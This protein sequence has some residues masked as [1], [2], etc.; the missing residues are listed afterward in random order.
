MSEIRFID[1]TTRDGVQSLWA[2]RLTTPQFLAIA[3]VMDSAGFKAIECPMGG[4]GG[5]NFAPRFL[6]EHPWERF[7]LIC[8]AIKRTPLRMWMRSRGLHDFSS[9]P[10]PHALA[11][12]W[13][14]RWAHYGVRHVI[15]LEEENDFGNIPELVRHAKSLGM[16]VSTPI[17]YSLSPV[18]TPEYYVR[19]AKEAI[20]AGTD[21]IEIKDQGGLLTPETTRSFVQAI[22]EG[23]EGKVDL[24]F[25]THCT[26]GLGLLSTLEAIRHGITSIR[27][28]LPPLAEG[29][30][31]PSTVAIMRNAAYM[32]HTT[33]LDP[34]ALQSISEHFTYVAKKEGLP[35][36]APR[37][38][39]VF[40]YDHQVPGG[41]QGTLRW[42]LAQLKSEHRFDEVLAETAQVRKDMGYPIMVTPASQFIVAQ[43]TMNVLSGERYKTVC[44]EVIE[45]LVL[46]SAIQPPGTPD[47]G[48]M[49]R[50]MKLPRTHQ[51][52]ERKHVQPSLEEMRRELGEDLSD[53]D[54]LFRTA[55]SKEYFDAVRGKS[56]RSDYPRGD[57]ALMTLLQELMQRKRSSIEIRKGDLYVSLKS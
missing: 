31:N 17:M 35:M 12:L 36:G 51:I 18:H 39:D 33:G 32:G 40:T 48:L 24:E 38:Y 54:F 55:A 16:G 1:S 42:Q 57:N 25:Q 43:A 28:C 46:K 15:F 4:P 21:V 29:S 47:P 26:T 19:K 45:K 13:L 3:P 22:Q 7:R 6:D 27:S 10:K 49:D 23:S 44:D 2:L 37:E 8:G 11:K 5:W 34:A 56:I 20:A 53:D 41:V 30:S 9:F 50:I 14:S 52:L